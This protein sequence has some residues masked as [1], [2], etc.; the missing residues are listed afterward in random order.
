[1]GIAAAERVQVLHVDDDPEF[2]DLTATFL[3]RTDDRLA[4]STATSADAG[5]DHLADGEFDCVVSDY[6]MPGRNGIEF[7]RAV[8][9]HDI[10]L[11]FILFTGKGSEEVA[12]DA[13]SAGVTDY[14][15]KTSG[16]D[17]Y[18][19]LANRITNAVAQHRTE[20]E[21]AEA[22]LILETIQ[23]N[24]PV[25]VFTL[26]TDG[27]FTRS[28]GGALEQLEMEPGEAVGESIFELFG[29]HADVPSQVRRALDGESVE[30]TNEIGDRVFRSWYEPVFDDGDVVGIVGHSVDITER[31]EYERELEA[32]ST[33]MEASI[34]GMA[35]LDA[36]E[37]YEFVNE[38]H[39]DIYG[40]DDPEA[41]AGESWRMCYEAD[42]LERFETEIMPEL[43]E[44]GGWRGEAVGLR[45]DGST[46]PQ[47]LSL[48]LT[49]DE[50]VICV[51]RDVAERR[52]YER[53]L[54]QRNE[55]LAEFASVVSHDLRNP[56]RVA[57]GRVDL[58]REDH[59]EE[60]LD[61]ID[62]SLDRMDRI[63]GDVL[64]LARHGRDI[65][66][67]DPVPLAEVVESAWMT[68]VEDERAELTVAPAESALPDIE[69]DRDRLRQLLENLFRNSVEH[70]NEGVTVTVGGTADGFYVADDG[71]GI[72]A[73]ERDEVFDAGYSTA[74]DGTGFGLRIVEQVVDA[75]GWAIQVAESEAGGA[76]FEIAGI[77]NG[78]T[79][80][81]S[82][83]LGRRRRPSDVERSGVAPSRR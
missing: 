23:K 7:L 57:E 16:S 37:T 79:R 54:E 43:Y 28:E 20:A 26:D 69:A 68:A 64:W 63:I 74:D 22:N 73:D 65:G 49:E 77:E 78:D 50:R 58:L 14:L 32:R 27:V 33:A 36:D 51:V 41:F 29:D 40:Y 67:V 60:H 15:Q 44:R 3:E 48:S 62:R 2:A 12:S 39:A 52:E 46:F 59:D 10:D 45:K 47:E 80:V 25:V 66:S 76:R 30:A 83:A 55:R 38:A 13:I 19:V 4:V 6:D 24:L 18:E 42:E 82:T 61:A 75:H 81:R 5:L 31:V 35:V 17:Q 71:P 53:E 11:P 21:L 9:E 8:R 72:P 34:D 70:G 1:M 56:L